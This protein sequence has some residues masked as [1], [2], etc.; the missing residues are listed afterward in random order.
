MAQQLD[1]RLV[2]LEVLFGEDDEG[3]AG[4]GDFDNAPG[5]HLGKVLPGVIGEVG[6]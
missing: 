6:G 4:S 1:C 3:L 2:S 5:C